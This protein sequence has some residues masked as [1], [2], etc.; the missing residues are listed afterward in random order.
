MSNRRARRH[1]RMYRNEIQKLANDDFNQFANQ[2]NDRTKT[3]NNKYETTF[4]V[5]VVIAVL[6]LCG[7]FIGWI[8]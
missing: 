7:C 2:M 1:R 4:Y 5:A 8:F 3:V 6:L